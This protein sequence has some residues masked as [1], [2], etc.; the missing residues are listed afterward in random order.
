MSTTTSVTPLLRRRRPMTDSILHPDAPVT[1]AVITVADGL[2]EDQDHAGTRAKDL[3]H[4]AGYRVEF[5]RIVPD[6]G[7]R[8]RAAF[9][10]F[11]PPEVIA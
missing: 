2:S 3:F 1:C 10:A 9:A 5:Y 6:D 7:E 8:L 4:A 11:G